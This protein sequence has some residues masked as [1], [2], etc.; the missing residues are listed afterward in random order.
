V[1]A[2]IKFILN[3]ELILIPQILPVLSDMHRLM[4]IED[5]INQDEMILNH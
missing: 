3:N 4:L 5:F 2:L 1:T